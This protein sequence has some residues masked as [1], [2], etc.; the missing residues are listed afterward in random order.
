MFLQEE[1]K[2]DYGEDRYKIFLTAMV[3]GDGISITILGGEKPHVGGMA[4]SVPRP[5]KQ[6]GKNV[7]DTWIIP[8]SEHRD[9]EVASLV[10]WIVGTETGYT[11]AVVAGIHID[12]AQSGE[13]DIIIKNSREAARQLCRKIK[14][15]NCQK[16]SI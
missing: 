9:S 16:R 2:L 4:M 7:C 3:T 5:K 15:I 14:E 12:N 1:I 10:S 13:I 11:T 8:R 6:N